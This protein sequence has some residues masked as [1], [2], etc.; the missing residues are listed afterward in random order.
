MLELTHPDDIDDD[1]IKSNKLRNLYLINLISKYGWN[2]PLKI[3]QNYNITKDELNN[4]KGGVL[5]PRNK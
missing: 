5:T 1:K 4:L 3:I 2:I